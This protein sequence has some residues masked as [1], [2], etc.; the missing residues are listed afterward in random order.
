MSRESREEY[1]RVNNQ[2]HELQQDDKS[3]QSKVTSTPLAHLD[4]LKAKSDEN[5]IEGLGEGK[6]LSPIIKELSFPKKPPRV[7]KNQN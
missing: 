2:N 5:I 3:N 6:G 1:L 4:V 7:E